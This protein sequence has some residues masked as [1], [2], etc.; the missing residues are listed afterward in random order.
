MPIRRKYFPRM[1]CKD[2]NKFPFIKI[3]SKG[4]S[5]AEYRSPKRRLLSYAFSGICSSTA[6][7][8]FQHFPTDEIPT[9]S[10]GE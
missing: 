6:F 9:L 10:S 8:K 3:F 1:G 7:R 5:P 4:D 2:M